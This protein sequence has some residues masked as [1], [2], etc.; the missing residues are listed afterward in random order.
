MSEPQASETLA[1]AVLRGEP[2]A[3]E[4]WLEA[5]HARVWKL[6][7]GLLASTA[8][9][10]DLAQ[11]AMLH[12]TDHLAEWDTKRPYATWRNAVVANLCRDRIRRTAAR[13]RAEARASERGTDF[14][15]RLPDPASA[16]HGAEVREALAHA[17]T[18]LPPRE[19]EVFV[20]RDLEGT[21][22]KA[23]A[24]ALEI[25]ESSVRSLLTLARRRL[26]R[27]IGE[28]VPGLVPDS[29]GSGA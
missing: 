18:S 9:A 12:L 7:F 21:A 16:A 14:A 4:P 27:L 5:E 19:R 10:D 3:L 25:T 17:L 6:C 20:L 29:E 11:D 23:V 2:D 22:T 28:R 1:R 24:D 8:E 15:A 26:R 13:R